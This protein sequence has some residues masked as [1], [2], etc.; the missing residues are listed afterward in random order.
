[1]VNSQDLDE[2][3]LAYLIE[4]IPILGSDNYQLLNMIIDYCTADKLGKKDIIQRINSYLNFIYKKVQQDPFENNAILNNTKNQGKINKIH[5]IHKIS[6]RAL[7]EAI[8]NCTLKYY[9]QFNMDITVNAR[10]NNIGNKKIHQIMSYAPGVSLAQYIINH[11]TNEELLN[12][13]KNIAEILEYLQDSFGFIH[14][15][16]H[17]GNIFIRDDGKITII[18]FGYSTIRLPLK[19]GYI[20]LSC[21]VNENLES[22]FNLDLI[23]NSKLKAI[24]LFSLF[25]QLKIVDVGSSSTEKIL[26]IENN[27]LITSICKL[28]NLIEIKKIQEFCKTRDFLSLDLSILYPV[29]FKSKEMN[30]IFSPLQGKRVANNNTISGRP[31]KT[32]KSLFRTP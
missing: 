25:E 6:A 27:Y 12:T 13:F 28:Y 26:S 17:Q 3:Y 9:T 1:M 15:D 18:D 14:G 29:N 23:H 10:V 8:I 16:F 7:I 24:D 5:K 19:D 21:P 30:N 4:H 31:Q 11:P 20:I 32:A 2:E 22:E